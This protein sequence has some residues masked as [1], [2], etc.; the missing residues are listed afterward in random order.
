[1]QQYILTLDAW[2]RITGASSLP[3]IDLLRVYVEG[4]HVIVIIDEAGIDT[5]HIAMQLQRA[6]AGGVEF[7]YRPRLRKPPPVQEPDDVDNNPG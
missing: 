5:E 4:L 7:E 1:M 2:R 3:A 6:G